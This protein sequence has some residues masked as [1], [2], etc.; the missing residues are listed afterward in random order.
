MLV[1]A[2]RAV[3]CTRLQG[4]VYLVVL[5]GL[6]RLAISTPLLASSA[7]NILPSLP[8]TLPKSPANIS[9]D[10]IPDLNETISSSFVLGPAI[11][12]NS[13][14]V[15]NDNQGWPP[16]PFYLPMRQTTGGMLCFTRL[17]RQ[18]TVEQKEIL[19]E[20]VFNKLIEWA[21]RPGLFI[22][23]HTPMILSELSLTFQ[24]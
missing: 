15:D 6:F 4:A 10:S 14:S 7:L 9:N 21:G 1:R 12:T 20:I 2:Y 11:N 19:R 13:T 5:L 24:Y 16:L 17:D 22:G 18:G 8:Q 3:S 23:P